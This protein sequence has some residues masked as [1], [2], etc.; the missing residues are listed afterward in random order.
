MKELESL[1]LNVSEEER[2]EALQYYEDY[3]EDA[4]EE[5]ATEVI[6][7]LG[8]PAKVAKSIQNDLSQNDERGE[9]TERGYHSG[10]E[11]NPFEVMDTKDLGKGL[12]KSEIKNDRMVAN[13]EG[14]SIIEEIKGEKTQNHKEYILDEQ[15]QNANNQN[16]HGYNQKQNYEQNINGDKRAYNQANFRGDD[17]RYQDARYYE[18]PKRKGLSAGAIILLCIFA[19]P[20]GI[21]VFCAL[22]GVFIG[23][24]AAVLGLIAGFG[25][26]AFGC[27]VSG[28]ILFVIGLMKVFVIPIAGMLMIGAGLLVFGIG[29]L[30]AVLTTACVKIIPSV[31]RGF[32]GICKAPFRMGGVIA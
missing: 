24:G 31:I 17:V 28:F 29:L 5:N 27:I 18:Q 19:I 25:A 12:N 10:D 3:F 13:K 32:V 2:K 16:Q 15:N 14:T 30:F 6:E 7:K 4:G 23:L 9:F 22:F 26:A 8:S 11:V 1:L 20:V 21:P